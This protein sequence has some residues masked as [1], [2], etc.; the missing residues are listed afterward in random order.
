M[1]GGGDRA[2]PE[3]APPVIFVL[4]Y[5]FSEFP[6][7]PGLAIGYSDIGWSSA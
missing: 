7:A 5:I 2:L 3:S 4:V 1:Q 6:L